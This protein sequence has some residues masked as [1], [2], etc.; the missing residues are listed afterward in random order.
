M[1]RERA[2]FAASVVVV[3]SGCPHDPAAEIC[4]PVA[5]GELV[6]TELRGEQTGGDT[7]GQWVEL[8][9]PGGAV[10]L[11]GAVLDLRSLDGATSM[12]LLVRE[13]I[14]IPGGGYLVLGQ[15]DGDHVDLALG[16]DFADDMP[17]AGVATL[18]A[19][20]ETID[21]VRWDSMPTMGSRSL[22][23][24]PPTA[25]GNDDDAAWCTDDAPSDDTTMLG[26]PGTPGAANRPCGT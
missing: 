24:T 23:E 26:L 25:A 8:H 1:L 22:G 10:S 13:P 4:P 21:E 18:R 6:I 9:S 7:W 17:N 20:G 12:R 19:C 3:L 14:E 2:T 11:E 15:T 16:A 5:A